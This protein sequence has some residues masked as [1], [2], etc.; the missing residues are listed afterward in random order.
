LETNRLFVTSGK[1]KRSKK[2]E[3]IRKRRIRKKELKNI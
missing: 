1:Q 3:R 2:C